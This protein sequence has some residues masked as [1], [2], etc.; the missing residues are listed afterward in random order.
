LAFPFVLTLIGIAII[1][2]A[3]ALKNNE[4]ALQQ[5]LGERLRQHLRTAR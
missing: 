3:M 2:S 1:G 4:A 5:K